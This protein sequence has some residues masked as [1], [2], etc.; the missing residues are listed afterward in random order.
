MEQIVRKSGA[1]EPEQRVI[2]R[3]KGE[4][5]QALAHFHEM[6]GRDLLISEVSMMRVLQTFLLYRPDFGYSQVGPFA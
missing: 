2:V 4:V 6:T 3:M 5:E 1:S